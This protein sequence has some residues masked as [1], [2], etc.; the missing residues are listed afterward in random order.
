MLFYT[1]NSLHLK[2]SNVAVRRVA[3]INLISIVYVQAESL[4]KLVI[5]IYERSQYKID[6]TPAKLMSYVLRNFVVS[7]S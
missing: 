7:F 6:F 1:T 5:V 4:K 2:T 3:I